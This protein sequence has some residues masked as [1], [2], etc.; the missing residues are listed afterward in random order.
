MQPPSPVRRGV[1]PSPSFRPLLLLSPCCLSRPMGLSLLSPCCLSRPTSRLPSSAL[2]AFSRPSPFQQPVQLGDGVVP[3]VVWAAT[4]PPPHV[5]GYTADI[6]WAFEKKGISGHIKVDYEENVLTVEVK[7]PQDASGNTVRD[8]RGL[9][10][11]ERS[12]STLCFALALHE[13]TEAPFRAMNEFDVFMV[14]SHLDFPCKLFGILIF[15][16]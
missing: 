4:F 8:T 9:S 2:S 13:M 3:S 12:F 15:Q 16:I 11:G 10:G 5:L 7:M 1:A 14:S 6:Q